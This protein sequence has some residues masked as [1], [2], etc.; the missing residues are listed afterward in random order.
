MTRVQVGLPIVFLACLTTLH[1]AVA[2]NIGNQK[3][4]ESKQDSK[5]TDEKAW[6][7]LV[8]K[9]D[10]K[11]AVIGGQAIPKETIK[12]T[13][14]E[15]TPGRYL[16]QTAAGEQKGKIKLIET[17]SAKQMKIESYINDKQVT[18]L[19]IYK[20]EKDELVLCYSF[21]DKFPTEFKSTAE[22]GFLL[23]RY[24]KAAK[25]KKDR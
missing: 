20:F 17:E 5:Q 23:A 7:P 6:K 3:P 9:W 4:S 24:A 8:G 19:T 13:K 15:M 18:F 1:S 12:K 21:G 11:S 2:Q 25:Q 16:A 14:L 10:C 22:N